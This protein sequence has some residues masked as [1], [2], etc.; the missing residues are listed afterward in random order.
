MKPK[1][2]QNFINENTQ[3]I[4][5]MSTKYILYKFAKCLCVCDVL[6]Q[7]WHTLITQTKIKILTQNFQNMILG[8][9][10]VHPYGQVWPCPPSLR[11]GTLNFLQVP[12]FLTPHSWH[13]SNK[14]INTKLSGYL[15]LGQ[16]RSSMTFNSTLRNHQCPSSTPIKERGFLIHL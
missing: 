11:S 10:Q 12:P 4:Q 15:S 7:T 16:T 6:W 13:T 1:F 3:L 9:Y 8:V 5:K 2:N 14:D